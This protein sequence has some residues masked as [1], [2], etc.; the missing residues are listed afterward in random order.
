MFIDKYTQI[1]RILHPIV[2]T[3]DALGPLTEEN[4]VLGECVQKTM[5]SVQVVEAIVY[6]QYYPY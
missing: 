3:V 6:P 2:E 5:G 1:A 4:P